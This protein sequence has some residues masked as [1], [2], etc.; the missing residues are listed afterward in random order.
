MS[1]DETDI[2]NHPDELVRRILWLQKLRNYPMNSDDEN[3]LLDILKVI[4]TRIMLLEQK[5]TK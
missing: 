5:V 4:A 3:Q 2:N 1:L